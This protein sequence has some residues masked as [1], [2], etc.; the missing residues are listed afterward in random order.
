VVIDTNGRPCSASLFNARPSNTRQT[1][2]H[3]LEAVRHKQSV[4]QSVGLFLNALLNFA[5]ESC[6]E[7][8]MAQTFFD[9]TDNAG[10]GIDFA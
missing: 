9:L 1:L 3:W 10:F 2:C 8:V 6:T 4:S 7:M 5:Q